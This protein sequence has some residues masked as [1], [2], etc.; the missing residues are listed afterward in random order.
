[1]AR[2][3]R[4]P[5]EA[6][7]SQE[8]VNEENDGDDDGG[9]WPPLFELD[10]KLSILMGPVASNAALTTLADARREEQQRLHFGESGVQEELDYSTLAAGRA[11]S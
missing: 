9:D 10:L 3:V 11:G 1:M 5:S 8:G 4:G 7:A 6:R 2:D